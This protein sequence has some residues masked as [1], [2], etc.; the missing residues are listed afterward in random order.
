M[1]A[2]LDATPSS[3]AWLSV[4]QALL[5]LGALLALA[6]FGRRALLRGSL[7]GRRHGQLELEERLGIDLRNALVIVRVEDRRLLL[8]TSDH[9][10][11]RLITELGLPST[12]EVAPLDLTKA[13]PPSE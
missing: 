8:A 3:L 13:G 9:G 12:S 2:P 11:A 6:W 4:L 10:P 1:S 5:A 7:L